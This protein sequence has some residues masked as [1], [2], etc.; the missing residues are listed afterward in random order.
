MSVVDA[1]SAAPKPRGARIPNPQPKAA[2]STGRARPARAPRKSAV[3]PK[4]AVAHDAL[5]PDAAIPSAGYATGANGHGNADPAGTFVQ[6]VDAG[7]SLL[8]GVLKRLPG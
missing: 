5:E 7:A 8:R 3:A 6:I 1:V 2:V 4:P